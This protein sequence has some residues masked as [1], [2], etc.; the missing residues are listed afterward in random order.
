MKPGRSSHRQHEQ[1]SKDP[2]GRVSVAVIYPG[3]AREGMASLALHGIHQLVSDH[4]RALCERVFFQDTPPRSVESRRLLSSFDL[5]AFT[6]AFE[7]QWVLLPRMLKSAG[8]PPR[9]EERHQAHP[10]VLVG[11]FAARLNPAPAGKFA[12]LI[13]AG[14]AECVL[15]QILDRLEQ[16][17]GEPREQLLSA[18]SRIGG[19]DPA[20]V[21]YQNEGGP[22]AQRIFDPPSSFKSMVLVETG[23]GCPAG[24]R[25]CAVAHARK[26]PVFFPAQDVLEAAREGVA[27][28]RKVGLVGASL[29]RHPGLLEMVEGL[30]GSGADFSP[31]SLGVGVL[32]GPAGER[33][34]AHLK[35][36]KQR[37][38]TLAP[39]TGSK[40]LQKAIGKPLV[41]D[42]FEEA[43][44]ED[45]FEEA[46]S[47]LGR[48]GILHL[49]LYFL[50]GLP[51]EGEADL[52]DS[53]DLVARARKWLLR[54]Q[55]SQG[56]TGRL[57]V[58]INPFVPKPHTPLA[59]ESMPPLAELK[60]KRK[61]LAEGLRRLGGVTVSG[62]SPR[63]AVWQCLLDRG[64]QSLGELLDRTDGRWPPP[65]GLVDEVIPNWRGLVFGWG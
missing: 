30:A 32:A 14:D 47:G 38:V 62:L 37:T 8:I 56:R 3:P 15:P 27:A 65:P 34:L 61:I 42:A 44:V 7:E 28:G 29:S 31:A 16:G 51:G 17:R 54:A 53:I 4:P 12:D 63:A 13:V 48:A 19:V 35:K 21:C 40:R 39:E 1:G 5:L 20:E 22:V 25:F 11:G 50:Y 6:V 45:A 55:R 18:L 43:L 58:S 24:C 60:R 10:V 52:Q 46:V 26:P 41:E 33:L 36:S 49:K 59:H 57:A 9:F 64:D 23:R 2:G